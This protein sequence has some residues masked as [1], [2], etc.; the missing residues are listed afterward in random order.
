MPDRCMANARRRLLR[1]RGAYT[2]CSLSNGVARSLW[3]S[4]GGES[5]IRTHGTLPSTPD[6]ESGT[7]GRS[8]ISPRRNVTAGSE[9]VNARVVAWRRF[10]PVPAHPARGHAGA[11]TLLAAARKGLPK[12]CFGDRIVQA[13]EDLRRDSLAPPR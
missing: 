1:A 6:F 5:G 9:S 12:L 11:D 4:T 13:M 8:V 7:F 3:R 2:L 10:G